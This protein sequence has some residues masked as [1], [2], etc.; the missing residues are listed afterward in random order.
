MLSKKNPI[1][2]PSVLAVDDDLDNLYLIS[3]VLEATNFRYYGVSDS[4]SVFDLAVDKAPNLILLD[5]VMPYLSGFDV[6]KQLKSNIVT[7]NIPVIA[8][9]GLVSLSHEAKIK[10]V[11]FDDYICKPFS[12]EELEAKI[13][14]H[15]GTIVWRSETGLRSIRGTCQRSWLPYCVLA[16]CAIPKDRA[17]PLEKQF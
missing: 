16:R 8:V 5:I 3:Y 11:G 12:V 17:S 13:A 14:K 15:L 4:R 7:R 9:T 1:S 6:I 2:V 10:S